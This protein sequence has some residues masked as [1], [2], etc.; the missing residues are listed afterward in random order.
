MQLN[1][2]AQ[3]RNARP[4]GTCPGRQ[5]KGG[6]G[7]RK[8]GV[9]RRREPAPAACAHVRSGGDVGPGPRHGATCSSRFSPH[10]HPPLTA[11]GQRIH[12]LDA[13]RAPLLHMPPT[14]RFRG[15]SECQRAGDQ[16]ETCRWAGCNEGKQTQLRAATGRCS[17]RPRL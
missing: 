9:G 14:E 15:Q 12:P 13:A 17:E 16:E 4:H 10:S 5:R 3:P 2:H 6:P 7:P 11:Q 8:E 1:E